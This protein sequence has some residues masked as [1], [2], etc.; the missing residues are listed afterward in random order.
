MEFIKNP[1]LKFRAEIHGEIGFRGICAEFGSSFF[2]FDSMNPLTLFA[3]LRPC[4]PYPEGFL[5]R[6]Y[7][8]FYSWWIGSLSGLSGASCVLLSLSLSLF[9]SQQSKD[10]YTAKGIAERNLQF[11]F[12]GIFVI[13]CK[14][15]L[16]AAL[17]PSCPAALWIFL[18]LFLVCFGFA[19]AA[20]K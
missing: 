2:P 3:F 5:L 8:K 6:N 17:C 20:P 11:Y 4:G 16:S 15:C 9:L 13:W 18:Y 7:L 19:C 1:I 12:F 14:V 10:S